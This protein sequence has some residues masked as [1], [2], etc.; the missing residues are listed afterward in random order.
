MDSRD[1]VMIQHILLEAREAAA[2]GPDKQSGRKEVEATPLARSGRIR[3][4]AASPVAGARPIMPEP[5]CTRC[6]HARP[7]GPR[8]RGPPH[9]AAAREDSSLRIAPGS[10]SACNTTAARSR[11]AAPPPA[12]STRRAARPIMNRIMVPRASGTIRRDRRC[13][14]CR[15]SAVPEARSF[16]SRLRG[17]RALRCVRTACATARVHRARALDH[18]RCAQV[19]LPSSTH[20]TPPRA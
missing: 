11:G 6:A 1:N 17:V 19:R 9:A 18:T 14:S 13:Y 12:A 4:P 16:L 7:R 10:S 3:R 5:T 20:R 15:H 2:A 8:A